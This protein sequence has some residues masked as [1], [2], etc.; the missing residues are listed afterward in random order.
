MGKAAKRLSGLGCLVGVLG[1]LIAVLLYPR[2]KWLFGLVLVGIIVLALNHFLAK[3]PT[4]EDV[5]ESIESFVN[6]GGGPWDWDN[7]ISCS[8]ADKELEEV[9]INR[10]CDEPGV[11]ALSELARGL[12]SKNDSQPTSLNPGD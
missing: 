4:R 5:A 12:R 6:G 1:P 10:W 2:A 9:R 7:F 3:K 11:E 8:I